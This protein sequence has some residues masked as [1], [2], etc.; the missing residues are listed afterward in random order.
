MQQSENFLIQ[1]SSKVEKLDTSDWPLLL[2]VFLVQIKTTVLSL[3]LRQEVFREFASP[4]PFQNFDKL[5]I[6]TQHY[7]PIPHGCSPLKRPIEDY[8]R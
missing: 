8:V 7:T 1:P 2:K 4:I 3:K 6:R 5:N